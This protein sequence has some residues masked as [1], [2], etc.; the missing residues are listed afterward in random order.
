MIGL[1][2]FVAS[3]SHKSTNRI[4]QS[5]HCL[6]A[7]YESE[8]RRWIRSSDWPSA[9]VLT[10]VRR[11]GGRLWFQVAALDVWIGSQVGIGTRA[12]WRHHA[13]GRKLGALLRHKGQRHRLVVVFLATAENGNTPVRPELVVV[14]RRLE[15]SRN[16]TALAK[17]LDGVDTP[18]WT[19]ASRSFKCTVWTDQ[20]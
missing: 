4:E 15:H 17:H 9:V 5:D 19:E 13:A 18:Y 7:K 20:S 6:K 10:R 16:V 1:G 14:V 3:H 8:W 12:V 11:T 2:T